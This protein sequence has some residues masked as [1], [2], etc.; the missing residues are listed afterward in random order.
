[1]EED[2][3][4]MTDGENRQETGLS[5][6]ED[7]ATSILFV[8]GR[9]KKLEEMEAAEKEAEKQ[10][11]AERARQEVEERRR[12]AEEKLRE[13]EQRRRELEASAVR[14]VD[15]FVEQPAPP[16]TP[17][18][19]AKPAGGGSNK[20]IFI[21]AGA[22]VV[23]LAV[24]LFLV[25]GKGKGGDSDKA[26]KASSELASA[27]GQEAEEDTEE[28]TEAGQEE[29]EEPVEE[30]IEK[31][32]ISSL[33]PDTVMTFGADNNSTI[34]VPHACSTS[35]IE[36]EISAITIRDPDGGQDWGM[37]F[38]VYPMGE[39]LNELSKDPAE[40]QSTLDSVVTVYAENV[41]SAGFSTLE[42]M[43]GPASDDTLNIYTSTMIL[44]GT[45]NE[46]GMPAEVFAEARFTEW[47]SVIISGV[48][49][50]NLEENDDVTDLIELSR[51]ML[52][53]VKQGGGN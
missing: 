41:F 36:D 18:P 53:T 5:N 7:D 33:E 25:L 27:A 38:S 10:R 43:T 20:M 47:G 37:S 6:P 50:M 2:R 8:T 45:D 9:K 22:A 52:D 29:T 39:D 40:V 48:Q 1:M 51:K 17:A 3:R 28:D 12:Q 23:V 31:T 11:E 24:V 4:N 15:D 35:E 42:E 13:E 26:D 14:T 49:D 19:A 34:M 21:I 44:T 30:V 16:S 32:P 46:T